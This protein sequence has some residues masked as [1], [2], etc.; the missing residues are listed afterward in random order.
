MLRNSLLI[1]G[2]LP[3]GSTICYKKKCDQRKQSQPLSF[4]LVRQQL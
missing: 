4:S 1:H 2:D 3:V